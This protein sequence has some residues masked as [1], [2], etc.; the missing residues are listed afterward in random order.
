MEKSATKS[1]NSSHQRTPLGGRKRSRKEHCRKAAESRWKK[2]TADESLA[3]SQLGESET[4][5]LTNS[6]DAE[7]LRSG[8]QQAPAEKTN[9]PCMARKKTDRRRG[10][11]GPTNDATDRTKALFRGVAKFA[12]P[13]Y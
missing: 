6:G 7:I 2:K 1:L 10:H 5:T 4:A 11:L 8:N 12:V 13:I 9:D 3:C